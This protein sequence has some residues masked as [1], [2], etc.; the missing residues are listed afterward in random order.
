M[1]LP[2]SVVH[3]DPHF[4]QAIDHVL[5]GGRRYSLYRCSRA[6]FALWQAMQRHC[7]FS[8]SYLERPSRQT[9][10]PVTTGLM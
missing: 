1:S 3:T 10:V 7:P 9:A 6:V 8:T 2:F 5:V 4:K